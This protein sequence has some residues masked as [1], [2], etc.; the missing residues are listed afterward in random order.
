MPAALATGASV[1]VSRAAAAA[2]SKSLLLGLIGPSPFSILSESVGNAP[3]AHS[4]V[5]PYLPAK[6]TEETKQ[7]WSAR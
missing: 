1:T 4:A 7:L 5:S 2:T 6:P 3:T